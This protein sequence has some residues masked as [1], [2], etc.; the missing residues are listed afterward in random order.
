[1]ERGLLFQLSSWVVSLLL[2][3]CCKVGLIG[4]PINVIP[5]PPSAVAT[6]RRRRQS[7]WAL[8]SIALEIRSNPFWP[9]SGGRKTLWG[10]ERGYRLTLS[11][12]NKGGNHNTIFAEITWFEFLLSSSEQNRVPFSAW[13][14]HTSPSLLWTECL[15]HGLEAFLYHHRHPDP[16]SNLPPSNLFLLLLCS[17]HLNWLGRF[18]RLEPALPSSF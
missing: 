11:Q 8:N 6:L 3:P 18:R 16:T 13:H 14:F 10:M 9:K 4:C 17:I 7:N 1:M 15:Y 5:L 12:R 2:A